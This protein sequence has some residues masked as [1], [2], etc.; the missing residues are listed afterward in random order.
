MDNIIGTYEITI[1]PPSYLG[2]KKTYTYPVSAQLWVDQ[3]SDEDVPL[4]DA[5]K[6]YFHILHGVNTEYKHLWKTLIR[7]FAN[8]IQNVTDIEEATMDVAQSLY[9]ATLFKKLSPEESI[10]IFLE[11]LKHLY[12]DAKQALFTSPEKYIYL[13]TSFPLTLP[14]TAV[15]EKFQRNHYVDTFSDKWAVYL[16]FW[17]HTRWE[18]VLT[19]LSKQYGDA[20][21]WVYPVFLSGVAIGA[22]T[23]SSREFLKQVIAPYVLYCDNYGNEECLKAL[24]LLSSIMTQNIDSPIFDISAGLEFIIAEF[25]DFPKRRYGKQKKHKRT[26]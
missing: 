13:L 14:R 1:I 11:T 16:Y 9:A 2:D 25:L 7:S 20:M 10:I 5:M 21:F 8:I 26:A 6:D 23:L 15:I 17:L 22:Y 19:Y 24:T 4:W 18:Y 12:P 3:L